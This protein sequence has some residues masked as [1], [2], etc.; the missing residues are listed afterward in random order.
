M[1]ILRGCT[2]VNYGRFRILPR[3]ADG[4]WKDEAD[5]RG[6]SRIAPGRTSD[7]IQ[8]NNGTSFDLNRVLICSGGNILVQHGVSNL[9]SGQSV[10]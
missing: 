3:S 8:A 5:F 7:S 10:L 4:Y 2:A 6:S 9:Q 1:G